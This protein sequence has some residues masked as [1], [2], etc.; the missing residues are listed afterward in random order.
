M[1]CSNKL[2][3]PNFFSEAFEREAK[4]EIIEFAVGEKLARC[5]FVRGTESDNSRS[6]TVEAE[7]TRDNACDCS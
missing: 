1:N 4:D 5:H 3:E 7:M 6:G 2:N